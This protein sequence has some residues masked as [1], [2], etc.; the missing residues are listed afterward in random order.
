MNSLDYATAETRKQY[1]FK[2][3]EAAGAFKQALMSVRTKGRIVIRKSLPEFKHHG[4][5]GWSVYV[6]PWAFPDNVQ[7]GELAEEHGGR[8]WGK[9]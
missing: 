1:T 7:I 4:N 5:P 2:T 6:T 9:F 3:R 8:R